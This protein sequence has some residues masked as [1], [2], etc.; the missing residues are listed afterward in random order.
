[1]RSPVRR[2]ALV[3]ALVTL[4]LSPSSA[5]AHDTTDDPEAH[6]REDL[7]GRSVESLE[8][9]ATAVTKE[10]GRRPGTRSG[11]DKAGAAARKADLAR[12]SKAKPQPQARASGTTTT[13][14]T[15]TPTPSVDDPARVGS[16]GP[17]KATPVV[18]VF[19]AVL[20]NG[21]ILMW[22]SVGDK[23]AES[24][25]DQSSTRAAVYDPSDGSSKRVDVTGSN[26][27]CA[28]FV[29]LPNGDVFVVGGNKNQQLEGIRE[30]HVF[31]WRTETWRR[32]PDMAGD[33]W[34]PTVNTMPDGKPLIVGGGPTTPEILSAPSVIRKLAGIQEVSDRTYFFLQTA[35]DGRALESGP[36]PQLRR[37]STFG[38]GTSEEQGFR[39]GLDRGYGSFARYGVGTTLVSGGGTAIV[40]G[41]SGA[42]SASTTLVADGPSQARSVEGPPMA[43]P[44]YGHNLTVLA[45]GSVVASGGAMTANRVD[46]TNPAYAAERYDPGTNTWT[47]MASAAVAREYH[48]VATLLPDGRVFTGGGGICGDCDTQGYLRKDAEIYTPPYLYAKDGSLASRPTISSAPSSAGYGEEL[49]VAT[50]QA[51]RIRKVAMVKLG[52]V[53]HSIDQGQRYVPLQFRQAGSGL[54][55]TAPANPNEAPPGHYM[56]FVVDQDGVP[57]VS[58]IVQVKGPD[59]PAPDLAADRTAT[60]SAACAAAEGPQKAFNGSFEAGNEDKFCSYAANATVGV[61]L[62]AP[63]SIGSVV[64]RHAGAGGEDPAQNTRD[65]RIQVSDDGTAWR[66][67]STITGNTASTTTSIPPRQDARYVRVAVDRPQQ[68]TG[69]VTRI[70]EIEVYATSAPGPQAA[71]LV[72]YR[73]QGLAGTAQTFEV[74]EFRADR[75]NLDQVGNDQIRSFSV[76]AGYRAVV[77]S[78]EDGTGC[79]TYASGEQLTLP[80]DLD[81]AISQVRVA[82]VPT[83]PLTAYSGQAL[84]GRAQTFDVGTF[85]ADRRQLDGVGND[86]IRS[87]TVSAGYRVVACT[88][89]S[90]AV[91]RS[92]DAGDTLF[93][94]DPMD[95]SISLLTVSRASSAPVTAYAGRSLTGAS[96]T[97]DPGTY[98]ADRGQLDGVGNDAIRSLSVASG[99][100][101]VGCT[102][103]GGSTC[104]TVNAGDTNSL[105]AP[106]DGTISELRVTK[107]P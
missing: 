49:S 28:G 27:F 94:G 17:V 8:K 7:V 102:D 107:L 100:R 14:P 2:A 15:P 105:A 74:G 50:P 82:P 11:E 59:V 24:Y 81:R 26:I 29:Q 23:A 101:V 42:A 106:Y 35:Q 3:A 60:G 88:D 16:F 70:Y 37:F 99:Y 69:D 91:C 86:A 33:R 77:C 71:P 41:G 4:A 103:E 68:G 44:R 12:A 9:R 64:V 80:A 93:L 31:D 58:K 25:P 22:D 43:L 95:R 39:D 83:G 30:T 34:Y 75:D 85:R 48:S 38:T 66:T 36:H 62:G 19:T 63:R 104:T 45:D 89:E 90:A 54:I 78:D 6:G 32:G 52:A 92:Y 96:Q 10:K 56:L 61:D 79:R 98:R 97:F 18:P 53:T 73:G 84:G 51:S 1:M 13:T 21:K 55:A 72:A 76:A 5:V 20:P 87:L 67:V 46:L 40:D 57:S 47:T 65:F